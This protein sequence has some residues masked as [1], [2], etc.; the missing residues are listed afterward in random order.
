MWAEKDGVPL[1]PPR[2]EVRPPREVTELEMEGRR[3]KEGR[4]DEQ[5]RR[6][7]TQAAC[8]TNTAQ[9]YTHTHTQTQT[10]IQTQTQRHAKNGEGE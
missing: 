8:D 9:T 2:G 7:S 6:L 5:A 10:Y 1:A 3:R 4:G